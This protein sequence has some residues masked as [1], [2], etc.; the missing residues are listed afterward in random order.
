[1]G[2]LGDIKSGIWRRLMVKKVED[3]DQEQFL[4]FSQMLQAFAKRVRAL[5]KAAGISG[6][7]FADMVGINHA[8]LVMIESG[9]GNFSI[10]IAFLIAD[11]FQIDIKLLLNDLQTDERGIDEIV[12][13]MQC[14]LRERE[15][16]R[17]LKM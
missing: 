8:T 4:R 6:R 7:Q 1:M 17:R 14:A 2:L 5:R 13:E 15:S 12:A 9:S 16:E 11:L 10:M 3:L